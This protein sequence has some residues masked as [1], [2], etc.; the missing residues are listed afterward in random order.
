MTNYA[1]TKI[2]NEP[3]TELHDVLSLTGAEIS[4]NNL[5]AGGSVPF[6]HSHKDN[7]EIY[8]IVDGRGK[9]VI[10]GKDVELEKGDWVRI[11]PAAKRQILRQVIQRFRLFVFKQSLVRSKT[12][13]QLMQSSK[14]N[15]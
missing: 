9:F 7:E 14:N 12:L 4:I 13:L 3:R 1:K 5:P 11:D 10:D 8:A 15:H 6:V 2:G